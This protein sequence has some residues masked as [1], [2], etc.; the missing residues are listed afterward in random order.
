MQGTS[1]GDSHI[2]VCLLCCWCVL[3][4]CMACVWQTVVTGNEAKQCKH[5]VI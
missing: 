3:G 4:L 5:V 1:E 2:C